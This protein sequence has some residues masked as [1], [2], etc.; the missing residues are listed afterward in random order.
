M[1]KFRKPGPKQNEK[2]AIKDALEKGKNAIEQRYPSDEEYLQMFHSAS[3]AI[4][5][6]IAFFAICDLSIDGM[7]RRALLFIMAALA[8]KSN[9]E[10]CRDADN[11]A[12]ILGSFDKALV[13]KVSKKIEDEGAGILKEPPYPGDKSYN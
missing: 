10:T 9:A 11:A 6:L 1:E 5:E 8:A 2:P 3:D 13:E 7:E 4:K 12:Y